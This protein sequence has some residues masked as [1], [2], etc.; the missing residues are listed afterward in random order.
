MTRAKESD[1]TP[2]AWA[3][4]AVEQRIIDAI[5]AHDAPQFGELTRSGISREAICDHARRL[6]LTDRMIKECRLSG[7][8]PAM[9]L[10]M[11]CD[12]RFLSS[13]IHNRLCRRCPPR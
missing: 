13:G 2:P 9:R 11:K 8:Q 3:S 4:P 6:G 1:S 12:A 10:C 7:T 5:V